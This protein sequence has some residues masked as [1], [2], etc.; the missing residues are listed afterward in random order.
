MATDRRRGELLAVVYSAGDLGVLGVWLVDPSDVTNAVG[1][2]VLMAV[3]AACAVALF[4]WRDR[5][6]A[7]TADAAI[8]G[9]VVLITAANLFCRLHAQ[10]GPFLPYYVWVGF[11]SPMVLP[12]RRA[13]ACVVLGMLA[14]GVV[15]LVAGHAVDV[16][17]WIVIAV[18][19]IVA[20]VTVDS[21]TG[22]V[23]ERE[24][25]AAVGEMASMV[26]HELRNPLAVVGNAV[27]LVRH[28]MGA[29]L[30]P[31]IER[32]LTMADREVE[33]ANAIIDHL[34]A[35][36]RPRQPLLEAVAVGAVV[37]EVLETTPAP[38]GVTVA[39]AVGEARLVT[40]RGQLAEILVNL[41]SNAY[42]VLDEGGTVRIGAA[43][44][45]HTVRLTVADDGAGID[46]TVGQ[47][48]FE[49]FVTTKHN[50]TGLGLAI[51]RRLVDINR[52]VISV[53]PRPGGGTVFTVTLPTRRPGAP[54]VVPADA[55]GHAP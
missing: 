4:A 38:A 12:R 17:A 21:L 48:I 52:G 2:G 25:L 31:D 13:M 26:T 39:V 19:L 42:D 33:K 27:F 9:S 51:V 20:F 53:A 14:P 18:T 6:P 54:N 3:V 5:L 29:G 43:V 47:R 36:V 15:A 1:L 45:D 37:E 23:V 28:A 30:S 24:R 55:V 49:P 10:V 34:V 22:M 35:F 41:V 50:G 7:F 44:G 16:A 11:A 40:D 8:G 32:H 46:E